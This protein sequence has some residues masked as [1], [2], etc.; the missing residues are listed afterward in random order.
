[1][2]S[3]AGQSGTR[4]ETLLAYELG[5]RVQVSPRLTIDAASFLNV[6]EN[7][8]S[9][10]TTLDMSAVPNYV[11]AVSFFSNQGE[12]RSY[13]GELRMTRHTANRMARAAVAI[14]HGLHRAPPGANLRACPCATT[15][16]GGM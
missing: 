16:P 8:R 9:T 14:V 13:G 3:V 12:G 6:Y 4:S 2:L 7:L 15:R 11:R 10:I 5:Y 1:V